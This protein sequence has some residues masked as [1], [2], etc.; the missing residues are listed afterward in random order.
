GEFGLFH[1]AMPTQVLIWLA[2]ALKK[3]GKCQIRPLDWMSVET[4]HKEVSTATMVDDP[5]KSKHGSTLS[6]GKEMLKP[7]IKGQLSIIICLP[8]FYLYTYEMFEA[9]AI[10]EVQ[11]QE[12]ATWE[13]LK[14]ASNEQGAM[15]DDD[16]ANHL[17][18]HDRKE[19]EPETNCGTSQQQTSA[20]IYLASQLQD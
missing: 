15:I 2:V 1:S 13:N 11:R 17:C 10:E 4:Q 12:N 8:F 6:N 19:N 16:T 20:A 18:K 3:R 9:S 5:D 7:T 14:G